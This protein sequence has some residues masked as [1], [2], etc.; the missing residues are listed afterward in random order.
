MCSML[1]LDTDK[2]VEP[3]KAPYYL[4]NQLESIMEGKGLG[5]INKEFLFQLANIKLN[6]DSLF[7]SKAIFVKF[8]VKIQRPILT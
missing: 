8:V 3:G 2:L 4:S 6:V 1:V 7:L 5:F